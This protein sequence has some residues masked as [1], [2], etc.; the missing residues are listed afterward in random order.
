MTIFKIFH[1][2]PDNVR[3]ILLSIIDNI[4]KAILNI[5]VSYLPFKKSGKYLSNIATQSAWLFPKLKACIHNPSIKRG[6]DKKKNPVSVK[7]FKIFGVKAFMCFLLMA[8]C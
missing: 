7:I 4:Q 2:F 8:I 1:N 5:V 6:I 3:L